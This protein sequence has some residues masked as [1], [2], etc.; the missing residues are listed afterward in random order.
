MQPNTAEVL[1]GRGSGIQAQS[2]TVAAE[3]EGLVA[4]PG[5]S[6]GGPVLL[7]GVALAA[8]TTVLLA[9]GGEATELAV[10]VHILAQPVDPGVV[11]DGSVGNINKDDLKVL[12]GAILIHP[13]GVENPQSTKLTASPLFSNRSLVP[14]ELELSDT[15]VLRLAIDN[16][17]GHRPL[18]ATTPHTDT[19]NNIALL[20]LEAEAAGLVGAGGPGE[21][22]DRR[23]LPVLPAAHALH[24][25]HYIGLLPPP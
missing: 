22:D 11:A 12:V 1:L 20:G 19:V 17:L 7:V 5:G 21:A 8:Q 4:L 6:P 3:G 16:T 14:L 10:L 18:P 23:L 13:V 24:E 15:L 2:S 9:S 25:A